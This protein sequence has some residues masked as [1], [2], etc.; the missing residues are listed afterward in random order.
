M[1]I[2]E[3]SVT[4]RFIFSAAPEIEQLP[5]LLGRVLGQIAVGARRFVEEEIE[6]AGRYHHIQYIERKGSSIYTPSF[7]DDIMYDQFCSDSLWQY[8][9][10]H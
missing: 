2:Y 1:S 5:E 8:T 9:F 7:T 6:G 3:I 4:L 10:V